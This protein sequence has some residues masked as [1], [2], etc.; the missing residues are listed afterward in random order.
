[1]TSPK[2]SRFDGVPLNSAALGATARQ[3][4][5]AGL[6]AQTLTQ[7]GSLGATMI[8]ARMLTTSDFGIMAVIQSVMGVTVLLAVSG[9]GA[10][11]I[12]RTSQ[13]A[14]AASSYFWILGSLGLVAAIVIS[15]LAGPLSSLLGVPTA[16][17]FLQVVPFGLP[18]GLMG[19]VPD[20]LLLRMRKFGAHRSAAILGSFTYFA[21]EILL[22]L[23]GFGVWSVI[24]GQ[25]IGTTVSLIAA[26]A[27]ARWAPLSRPSFTVLRSDVRNLGGLGLARVLEYLYKN[28]DYWA[29]GRSLGAGPLGAYYVAY[30]L[31]NIVRLRLSDTFRT[32]MLPILSRAGGLSRPELAYT[33]AFRLFLFV[34]LPTIAGLYALAD[35]II[36]V[37]FGD[38]WRGAV[39]PMRIILI[40]AV[41]DL[42]I[43]CVSAF[44]VAR[45]RVSGVA[46]TA[47]IRVIC[48]V[49]LILVLLQVER[50]TTSIAVG[51]AGATALTLLFQ[52][53]VVARPL[54]VSLVGQSGAILAVLVPALIMV[55]GVMLTIQLTN[56]QDAVVQ[57]VVGV[58]VGV[59]LYFSASAVFSRATLVDS[60]KQLRL[61]V[62]RAPKV[63]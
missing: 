52:E 18:L 31:P 22:V 16:R 25:M 44:A 7:L 46:A 37:F 21:I 48:T 43:Q 45:R 53:F 27:L 34:S 51:V 13:V 28:V 3:G 38:Q 59:L 11:L 2:G 24:A 33:R 54:G 60:V 55:A 41:L 29:V 19:M 57:L 42:V 26:A 50:S 49:M 39:A 58:P 20:A 12:T 63:A 9:I 23:R 1:M 4:V 35:P 30:V 6:I 17:P 47:A 14:E 8:M 56:V 15:L 40:G 62:G 36:D 61:L 32:V 10:T 5:R